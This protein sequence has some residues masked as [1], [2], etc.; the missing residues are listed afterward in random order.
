MKVN[1]LIPEP[2]LMKLS[3]QRRIKKVVVVGTKIVRNI[4]ATNIMIIYLKKLENK[5]MPENCKSPFLKSR[6]QTKEKPKK[7]R[8]R[9]FGGLY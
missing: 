5:I 9:V 2:T 1:K 3:S 6:S 7:K 4:Y 8:W